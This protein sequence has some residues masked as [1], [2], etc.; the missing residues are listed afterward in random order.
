MYLCLKQEAK[1]LPQHFKID[2][3]RCEEH[4]FLRARTVIGLGDCFKNCDC[5][6]KQAIADGELSV[7]R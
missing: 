5:P 1:Q 6:V 4:L 3:Y 7:A 2:I